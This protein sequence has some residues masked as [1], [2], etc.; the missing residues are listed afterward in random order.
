V[1]RVRVH[2][3]FTLV[4]LMVTIAIIGIAMAVSIPTIMSAMRDRRLQQE[5]IDFTNVFR[6]ARSRAMMRGQAHMVSLNL[7]G[8]PSE[9]T[10]VEARG[11][12]SNSCRL[13]NWTTGRVIYRNPTLLASTEIQVQSIAPNVAQLDFCFTPVGRMFYRLGPAMPFTE[14]NRASTGA[15]LNGGFFFRVVNT[16][17]PALTARRV[18]LPLGGVPRLAP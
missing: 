6:E 5:A 13:T 11:A 16:A 7:G 9:Q 18:F 8:S 15:A 3:G 10:I 14:D 2:P 1:R 17:H 4:E 12:S